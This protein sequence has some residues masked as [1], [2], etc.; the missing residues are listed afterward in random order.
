[1]NN[2]NNNNPPEGGNGGRKKKKEK[3]VI[4]KA[5]ILIDHLICLAEQLIGIFCYISFPS[6]N[7]PYWNKNMKMYNQKKLLKNSKKIIFLFFN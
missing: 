2:N 4:T 7:L 1:M 5:F 6:L 3:K